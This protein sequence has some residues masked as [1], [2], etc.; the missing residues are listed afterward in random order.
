[1]PKITLDY[2]TDV[3]CIWAY[4]AQIRLDELNQEFGEKIEVNEHFITLFG[5]TQTRIAEGWKDKGGFEGFNKHVLKV[6]EGFPHLKIN[7][8][9]WITC[10][11]ASS[12][13]SHLYLKAIQLLVAEAVVSNSDFQAM[14]LNIRKA[15]FQD[16]LDISKLSVLVEIAQSM[17][18]PTDLIQEKLNDGSAIAALCADMD[19]REKNKLEGSPT[20]LLDNGRQKLYGNVG[21]RV[22]EANIQELLERPEGIASWC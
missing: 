3:L 8:N 5:N 12:A 1:M 16:A 11:P 20:Y 7:P 21:Y 13:N 15:F 9:V 18:L 10:K 17:S 2:F 6:A 14:I 4:V 19:M 22:L